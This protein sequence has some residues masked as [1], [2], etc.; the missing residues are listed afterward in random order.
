MVD[1]VAS[2]LLSHIM[3]SGL[4]SHILASGLL[5]HILV[6]D[7][8]SL[9]KWIFWMISMMKMLTISN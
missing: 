7:L 5:S 4:L 6:S 1:A 9:G 8:P 3:V 2:E